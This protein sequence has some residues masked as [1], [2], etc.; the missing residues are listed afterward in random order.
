MSVVLRFDDRNIFQLLHI[1]K[2]LNLYYIVIKY[3]KTQ[4]V[5]F[6]TTPLYSWVEKNGFV[7]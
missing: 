4:I 3:N 7:L 5:I 1:I 6:L 2:M